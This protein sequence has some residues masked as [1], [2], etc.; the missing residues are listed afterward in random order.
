LGDLGGVRVPAL[1]RQVIEGRLDRL[2]EED[3]RL[4]AVAAVIGQEVPLDLWAAVADAQ[5][6]AL[7]P[8]VERAVE[9]RLL[10]ET[11]DGGVRFAHALIRE[12]LYE[13]VLGVRRRALH[14]RVGE[15]LAASSHPD[16]DAVAYHFRQAGDPRAAEWLVKAGER[17][18]RAYAWLTAAERYEAALAVDEGHAGASGDRT[19]LLLRLAAVHAYTDARR[20]LAHLGEAVR[21]AE[22][23]GDRAMEAYG[24][25][26]RGWLGWTAGDLRRGLADL[27]PGVIAWD[28][29]P[30]EE[31]ARVQDFPAHPG[32]GALALLLAW[33]GYYAKARAI[34]EQVLDADVH[35]ALIDVHAALGE[36]EAA[37]RVSTQGREIWGPF[38]NPFVA[39]YWPLRDLIMVAM[40][41][42]TDDVAGRRRLAEE[43]EAGFAQASG[44][45]SPVAA[46]AA[47]LPLLAL[48]GQ[49]E[50]AHEAGLAARAAR[51]AGEAWWSRV[52]APVLAALSQAQ[53]RAS[54]G[55]ELVW[56][57]HPAGPATEPGGTYFHAGR[58]VLPRRVDAPA[59]GGGAGARRGRPGDI[60]GLARGA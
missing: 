38:R 54:S 39:G 14:R 3:Q 35:A 15:A 58:D 51:A 25:A 22:A 44:M 50:E 13:G 19:R 49:W 23:A 36:V 34:A 26:L 2:G 56:E 46:R 7:Y 53:A 41:Y 21:R 60:A 52:A 55:W 57:A 5:E 43:A 32:Q 1:L 37:R 16:P 29:L 24:L 20:G 30:P 27:E 10:A 40:P 47:R 9:A 17:A 48:E 28:S 31:Q 33:A 45:V 4:L 12:A 11:P 8:A 42:A 18:Q 6:E 59:R